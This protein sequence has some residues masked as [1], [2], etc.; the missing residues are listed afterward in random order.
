MNPWLVDVINVVSL[1]HNNVNNYSE[2][3]SPTAQSNCSG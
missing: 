2:D 1:N 3:K